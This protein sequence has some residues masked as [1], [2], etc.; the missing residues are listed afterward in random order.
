ME[1]RLIVKRYKSKNRNKTQ[2]EGAK[3][4]KKNKIGKK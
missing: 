2:R 3:G 4:A 1:I